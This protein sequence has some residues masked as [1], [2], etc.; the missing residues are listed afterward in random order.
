MVC[1]TAQLMLT[2][3]HTKFLAEIPDFITMYA[4]EWYDYNDGYSRGQ[5]RKSALLSLLNRYRNGE[6]G[7]PCCRC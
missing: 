3:E 7:G 2:A 6:T 4:Y 1:Q 5:T